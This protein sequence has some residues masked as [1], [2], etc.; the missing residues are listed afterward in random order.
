MEV[1]TG[2][3]TRM[4]VLFTVAA[5]GQ[6]AGS[7]MLVRTQGF[8]Q[9]GWSLTCVAVLL[10]SF[11][12]IAKMYSEGGAIAF[13]VP[14]MAAVVPLLVV[15]IAVFLMGQPASWARIGLLTFACMVIGAAGAV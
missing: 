5:L 12:A 11:W 3:T 2:L 10:S 9:P 14:L 4:I 8:T 6:V 7:F 15:L 13:I 1:A